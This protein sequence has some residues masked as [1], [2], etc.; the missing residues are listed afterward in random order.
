MTEINKGLLY[1]EYD[2]TIC[3]YERIFSEIIEI[4]NGVLKVRWSLFKLNF[5]MINFCWY[6]ERMEREVDCLFF[7]SW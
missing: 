5:D 1:E 2:I 3:C 7:C 4:Y 6:Y